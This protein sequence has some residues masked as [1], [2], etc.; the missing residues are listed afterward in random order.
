MEHRETIEKT[1]VGT[2]TVMRRKGNED[3]YTLF[4]PLAATKYK[5]I[6]DQT[7]NTDLLLCCVD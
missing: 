6:K 5:R 2:T 4:L 7:V 3:H 1:V